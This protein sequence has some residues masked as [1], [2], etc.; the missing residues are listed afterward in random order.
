MG[1]DLLN[2][3]HREIERKWVRDMREW[4]QGFILEMPKEG[5]RRSRKRE[6]E[7]IVEREKEKQRTSIPS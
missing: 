7:L 5:E 4:V 2:K 1:G 6:K 3:I